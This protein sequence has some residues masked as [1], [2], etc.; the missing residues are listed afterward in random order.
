LHLEAR[1]G[2]RRPSEQALLP[3]RRSV[4]STDM[5]ISKRRIAEDYDRFWRDGWNP[6][7]DWTKL[8]QKPLRMMALGEIPTHPGLILDLGCGNGL[9]LAQL[10]KRHLEA[11]G[12][13]ISL[14]ALEDARSDGMVVRADGSRLPFSSKSFGCV[15]ILD[16]LEHVVEKASLIRECWRVL[17]DG[18][19][20]I[21]TTPLA[22]ATGGQG[23]PRQPYDKPTT[24]S[25][26]ISM[27]TQLFRLRFARGVIAIRGTGLSWSG[28]PP[29]FYLRFPILLEKSNEILLVLA[30][31]RRVPPAGLATE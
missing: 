12:C 11:V 21:I 27:T 19:V 5:A 2:T 14:R 29:A 24:Y 17:G 4:H 18:G 25:E 8:G 22:R 13:D 16:A 23:D 15:L 20:A 6:S 1:W 31:Q 3:Y 26:I 7:D 10:R 30:K 28:L 9:A